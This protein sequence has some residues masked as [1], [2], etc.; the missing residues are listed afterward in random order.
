MS[1]GETATAEASP[2]VRRCINGL[3]DR[4]A[5]LAPGDALPGEGRLG[6]ELG[7]SRSPLRR[8]LE[9]LEAQ[10][11]VVRDGKRTRLVRAVRRGDRVTDDDAP[12]SKAEAFEAWFLHAIAER[13]LRPGQ[14]FTE[15]EVAEAAGV[16]TATAREVLARYEARRL[17]AKDPRRSWRMERFDRDAI[18]E[19]WELRRLVERHALERLLANRGQ[20]AADVAALLAEH[21]SFAA[22]T[23][24]P[25][26][27]FRELDRRFHQLLFAASGNRFLDDLRSMIDLLIH[28]QLADDEIGHEGMRRGVAQHIVLLEAVVSG[29][30][31]AARQA[32]AEHMDSSEYIMTRALERDEGE[33]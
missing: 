3:C 4:L 6:D 31:R 5:A 15:V 19:L 2:L 20:H 21:R 24:W 23:R 26:V 12:L 14:G 28:V 11:V 33:G 1:R 9:H 18:A 30:R 32:L 16:T 22:R 17:I 7:V 27:G 10:G 13:R 8:A 25:L 29:D